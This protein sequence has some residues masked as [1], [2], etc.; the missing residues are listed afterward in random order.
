MTQ[1]SVTRRLCFFIIVVVIV[2][3]LAWSPWITDD[4]ATTVVIEFLGGPNQD[5]NY[6]G[7]VIPLRDVPKTI[8][9]V[10]FGSLVYFP[11]E[12]MFIVTFWGGVL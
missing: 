12:A 8:V 3:I 10:P 5:Y 9:R 7:D 6:L 1:K 11:S 4:Y 2:A